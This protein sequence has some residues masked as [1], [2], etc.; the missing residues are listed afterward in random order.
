[1][2]KIFEA[3]DF[4]NICKKFAKVHRSQISAIFAHKRTYKQ[5]V[6]A[7]ESSIIR[8]LFLCTVSKR[9]GTNLNLRSVFYFTQQIK[10][11]N[12]ATKECLTIDV[13]KVPPLE[14]AGGTLNEPGG[15]CVHPHKPHLY[16]ADTNNHA[17]KILD[18][19]TR[20][21][22]LVFGG[23]KSK[24]LQRGG[25]R[26]LFRLLLNQRKISPLFLLSVNRPL[27]WAN[28]LTRTFGGYVVVSGDFTP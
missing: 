5:A 16:I 17:V 2:D 10:K 18:L 15:I 8:R 1:M 28:H 3:E 9:M 22:S 26:L 7:L 25:G 11:I 24:A 14:D 13:T 27:C 20:Q 12:L 6:G 4:L 19:Q 21:L 23:V